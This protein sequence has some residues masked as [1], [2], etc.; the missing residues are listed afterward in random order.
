MIEAKKVRNS[1]QAKPLGLGL[2]L[3]LSVAKKTTLLGKSSPDSD[4]GD[5]PGPSHHAALIRSLVPRLVQLIKVSPRWPQPSQML[6]CYVLW[7]QI[8]LLSTKSTPTSVPGPDGS[9]YSIYELS[10]LKCHTLEGALS[11]SSPSRFWDIKSKAPVDF[12]WKR[13]IHR[14]CF[15]RR[16]V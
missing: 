2:G 4:S 16:A 15:V 6:R 12:T 5:W 13:R 1:S 10:A 7:P 3:T 9:N 11:V 14:R 8:D